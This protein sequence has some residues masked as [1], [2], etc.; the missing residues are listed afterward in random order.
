VAGVW[1]PSVAAPTTGNAKG[2]YVGNEGSSALSVGIALGG[3]AN[4]GVF[5]ANSVTRIRDITDG[6]TNTF[7]AGERNQALGSAAW[8]ASIPDDTYSYNMMTMM[9]M[10]NMAGGGNLGRQV[11]GSGASNPNA[12]G[13]NTGF[14]SL[15]VGGCHMLLGDGSVRF[16]SNNVNNTTFQNL[17]N[18]MDGQII[19]DF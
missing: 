19:G 15:H 7:L 2:N 18:R 5:Y 6:T 14:G 3:T 12:S 4:N 13:N 17:S 8:G 1:T 16:V 10:T 9:G 11:L